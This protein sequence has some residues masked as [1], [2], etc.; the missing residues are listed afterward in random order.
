MTVKLTKES[1]GR[2]FKH[3]G[4]GEATLMGID[5]YPCDDDEADYKYVICST[6]D[7][8]LIVNSCGQFGGENEEHPY[9]L[10]EEIKPKVALQGKYITGKNGEIIGKVPFYAMDG[11]EFAIIDFDGCNI[12]VEEGQGLE[13]QGEKA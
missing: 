5:P 2:R 6:E 1:V 8:S 13:Q 11:T 3:R 7:S 10:I 12:E 4:G 9:D